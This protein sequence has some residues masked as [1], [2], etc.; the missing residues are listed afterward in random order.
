[1][2]FKQFLYF[3][4]VDGQFR[5]YKGAR[6]LNSL[7]TFIEDKKWQ[8][9]EPVSALSKPDS[10][11]MSVVSYFFKLSHYMKEVNNSLLKEYGLP[12]W[13]SYAIFA[14]VTILLGAI[15]GL[16]LVCVIDFLFPPKMSQRQSFSESKDSDNKEFSGDELQ[17]E[18]EDEEESDGEKYSGSDSESEESKK[19]PP[20]SPKKGK[21]SKNVSPK[22]SPDVVR[23]RKPRKAD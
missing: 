2:K 22:G 23:K 12:S 3:S 9:I 20:S 5:Q 14:I 1:M 8:S 11:Q 16:L 15:L 13:A 10:I 19:S 4:V 18:L 17:D 21:E 6:D 7:M